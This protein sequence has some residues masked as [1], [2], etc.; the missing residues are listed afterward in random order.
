MSAAALTIIIAT[1]IAGFFARHHWIAD[2]FTNLRM[3]QLIGLLG[4]GA[5]LAIGRQWRWL[6]VT[7]VLL[8]IHMPWFA[9]PL[10]RAIPTG[11]REVSKSALV[12][13]TAN[14]LTS[15]RQHDAIVKQIE[16]ANA[17]VFAI[18]ELGSPLQQ[19]LEEELATSYPHRVTIP[20]D[21][22]NFGIGLYSRHPLSDI[23]SFSTNVQSIQSIAATVDSGSASYRIIATHPLPPVGNEGYQSR[24]EHMQILGD[25]VAKFRSAHK[26]MPVVVMGDL[27]LTP[28]SPLLTDFESRSGLSLA[29]GDNEIVPTWYAKPLFPF[30][31]VLDHVLIS[32]DLQCVGREIGPDIGSDHRAVIV[33]ITS[34]E[35]SSVRGR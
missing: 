34:K 13:M 24:N 10:V 31:L 4:I 8:C 7:I 25:R 33:A 2:I 28:W 9:A 29:G 19:R 1:T 23:E 35:S 20:Q 16:S 11:N 6:V 27:N 26:K 15:N 21:G 14:V 3:Q 18:L 22:G 5:V 17:D 32:D 12:V 30:G